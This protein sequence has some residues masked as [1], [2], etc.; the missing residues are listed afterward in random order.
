VLAVL[1]QLAVL[2]TPTEPSIGGLSGAHGLDK[3]VHASVFALVMVAGRAARLPRPWVALLTVVQA[4]L[5]EVVQ[6][7]V[8]SHRDGA[9]WDVV[10]DLAGCMLGWWLTR[11]RR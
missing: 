1:L 6:A 8:L 5:S 4:P 7:T 2:Y 10:A 11:D 9:P 3:L